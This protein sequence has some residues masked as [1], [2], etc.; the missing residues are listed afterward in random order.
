MIYLKKWTVFDYEVIMGGNVM[1]SVII[2]KSNT[3]HTEQYANMLADEL[4]CKAIPLNQISKVELNAYERIFFGGCVHASKVAGLN[5]FIKHLSKDTHKQ[6]VVFAVGANSTSEQNTQDLI[7]SNTSLT[8]RNIPFFYLQG[9]FDP[10]K[11]NFALRMMLQ[12]VA[13]SLKKKKETNPDELTEKDREFLNFFQEKNNHVD[14][15]NLAE[16]MSYIEK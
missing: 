13:K 3:G 7:K 14:V 10:D 11:L 5:T 2:F 6:V 12:G 15:K 4:G 16:L 9:G 1:N 8:E